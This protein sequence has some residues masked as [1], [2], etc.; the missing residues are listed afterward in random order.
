MDRGRARTSCGH[1]IHAD[2]H[3]SW[4]Y[5]LQINLVV[6]NRYPVWWH[7]CCVAFVVPDSKVNG[8]NMGPIWGRQDPGGPHVGPMNFAIWGNKWAKSLMVW[9]TDNSCSHKNGYCMS[10]KQQFSGNG[11]P[12]W[13]WALQITLAVINGLMVRA[14]DSSFSD[15]KASWL[16]VLHMIIVM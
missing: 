7:E 8:A 1:R 16:M 12:S 11:H 15:D 2:G 3:L 5:G 10:Y 9:V 6:T 14:T 13:W 4:W